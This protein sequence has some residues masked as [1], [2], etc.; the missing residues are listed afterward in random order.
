VGSTL[1]EA[2]E[3]RNGMKNCGRG[4]LRGSNDYNVNIYFLKNK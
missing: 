1:S 2:K 4:V 3:R